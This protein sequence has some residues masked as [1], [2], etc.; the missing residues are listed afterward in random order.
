MQIELELWEI[1]LLIVSAFLFLVL[2]ILTVIEIRN[3]KKNKRKVPQ[4]HFYA[5]RKKEK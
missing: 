3:S 4:D 2:I 5:E 1:I